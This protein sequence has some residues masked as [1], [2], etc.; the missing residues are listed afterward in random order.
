MIQFITTTTKK[1]KR[2]N[3]YYT[4]TI[5][6]TD[7]D[8]KGNFIEEVVFSGKVKKE[9]YEWCKMIAETQP[10]RLVSNKYALIIKN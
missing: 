8:S 6:N 4:Q 2:C 1:D 7:V 3:I 9:D 5:N 10:E